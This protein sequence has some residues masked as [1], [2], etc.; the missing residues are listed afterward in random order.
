MEN[1]IPRNGRIA[2]VDDKIE[3]ALPLMMVLSRN[4]IPFTF[5][6]GND[7]EWLP[8]TPENDVRILFLD[9]NLLGEQIQDEKAIRSS[10]ISV[11]KRIISPDNYPYIL[12]LW[13]R[14]ESEYKNIVE[15]IFNDTLKDC[16][17]ISIKTFVK[18]DFFPNFSEEIDSS[19]DINKILKELL[20]ILNDFPAYSHLLQWENQVHNSADSTIN[21]IFKDYHSHENWNENANCILD[22]FAS[23]YL[24]KQ[25]QSSDANVKAKSSMLFFNDVFHDTLEQSV[26]K[27]NIANAKDLRCDIDESRKTEIRA[28]INSRLLLSKLY[29]SINQPG[30][31]FS[32]TNQLHE[33]S[34]KAKELLNDSISVENIQN[35]LKN[36][37]EGLEKKEKNNLIN[38]ERKR[39]KDQIKNTMLPCGI[40]VTPACDYAQKKFKY[41]RIVLGII[42]DEE[43]KEY[44]DVKSEAIYISPI[45][46]FSNQNKLLILNYRYFITEALNVEKETEILFRV[47]NSVLSEIQSKLARHINRQGIMNL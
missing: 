29:D 16:A 4:N 32:C 44:I 24:E 35:F 34:I 27:T 43:Y 46:S 8:T 37:I 13:S 9:L 1:I 11:L 18:S 21:D 39:R 40:V 22:M 45:F 28:K 23:S 30:C 41:D 14:Q 19:K 26:E 7:S 6:K 36:K 31:V 2:I 10:L 5:Y 42:I 20:G 33:C 17:P 47:R 38:E 15:D 12:V 25:Y 3:Q